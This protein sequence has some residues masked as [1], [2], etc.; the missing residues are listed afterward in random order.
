[1]KSVLTITTRNIN[2]A[3][4]GIPNVLPDIK[5]YYPAPPATVHVA[6]GLTAEEGAWVGCGNIH[7]ILPYTLQDGYDRK[8]Q[9]RL[10]NVAVLENEYLRAEFSCDLGGR[11]WSLYSKKDNR[12][13]FLDNHVFQPANLALRNAW[14]S[15]GVEWNIGIIGHHP[16]TCSPM[17][18]ARYKNKEGGD[19]LKMYEYERKRGLAYCVRATLREDMLLVRVTI[20]NLSGRDSYVYWWS[21][22]AVIETPKSRMIVPA[23]T[24]YHYEYKEKETF[25]TTPEVES[26]TTYPANH[27]RSIDYFYKTE[28]GRR[29]FMSYYDGEGRGVAQVSTRELIGRKL[30]VWGTKN[31][32]GRNWNHWLQRDDRFYAEIQAGLLHSQMEQRPMP[33]GEVIEWT[34]GYISSVLDKDQ[35]HDEDY[36]R[37]GR[38]V[39]K[40]LMDEGRFA[41]VDSSDSCFE[42]DGEEEIVREGCAWGALEEISR[43]AD[44][45]VGE[46]TRISRHLTFPRDKIKDR[47]EGEFAGLFDGS[48]LPVHHADIT[49]AEGDAFEYV[50][51]ERFIK[52]LRNITDKDWYVWLQLACAYYEAGAFDE[53]KEA[54]RWSIGE[55][56]NFIALRSLAW[57]LAADYARTKDDAVIKEGISLMLRAAEIGGAYQRLIWDAISYMKSYGTPEDV[58]DLVER[59][60][61]DLNGG[62]VS[63]RIKL[64]YAQN[65]GKIGRY[66]E[67]AAILASAPE[68]SDVREGECS[69]TAIWLDVHRGLIAEIDSRP[70]D[71]VT[72]AEIFERYPLPAEMDFRM[73]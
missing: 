6:E 1:M 16:F 57:M 50:M 28:E 49:D 55:K 44:G 42:A 48:G 19:V 15:G 51:G 14:F 7:S 4:L 23:S 46:D 27:D 60:G 21:N 20:E 25:V 58:V 32:G 62:I 63:G 54:F 66:A 12:E 53:A 24:Y 59:S 43:E 40:N 72:D 70:A 29:P 13:L 35:I 64:F 47:L 5:P 56:E 2:G 73:S 33:A 65:L 36:A 3:N 18:I 52:A 71:S 10:M 61:V 31:A 30:F 45:Y 9:S 26:D 38:Y 37:V 39:E 68:V 8:L 34:E 69:T 11:L 67:A 22:C 41:A 17:F